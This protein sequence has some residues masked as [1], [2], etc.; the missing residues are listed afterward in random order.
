MAPSASLQIPA[1][2]S[3]AAGPSNS[4]YT[5]ATSSASRPVSVTVSSASATPGSS[6]KQRASHQVVSQTSPQNQNSNGRAQDDGSS[7]YTDVQSHPAVVAYAAAHPRRTIPRFGPYL[8]LQTLGEGEFGKVKLGLHSSWGEEVAVKLIRRGNVDSAVRM[9]K[10][11]RE[12]EVLR[13]SAFNTDHVFQI[14]ASTPL[15]GCLLRQAFP[16]PRDVL[17][18]VPSQFPC[19]LTNLLGPSPSAELILYSTDFETS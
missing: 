10:V 3:S 16:G 1:G 17:R 12:I 4:Q 9:S 8:L 14:S 15:V 2:D 6:R 7:P 11:E 19:G 5:S 13:V 18:R